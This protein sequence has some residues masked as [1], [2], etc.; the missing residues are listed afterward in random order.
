MAKM[1]TAGFKP[2][3][4]TKKAKSLIRN[5]MLSFYN[6]KEYGVKTR[7]EAMSKDANSY[8]YG[9]GKTDW[10]KGKELVNAGCFRCYYSD[11]AEFLSKI[12]GKKNVAKWGGH[13]IHDIYG[14]LIGR[15][16]AS[17]LREKRNKRK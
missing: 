2:K 14:N 15:E 8:S 1:F 17:M 7:L 13:K 16:Y 3:S 9:R 5:E 4:T 10:V 12:Y 11:Q 6:A